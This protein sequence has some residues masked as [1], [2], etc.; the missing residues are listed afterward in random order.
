MTQSLQ[1]YYQRQT[2][3]I[4]QPEDSTLVRVAGPKQIPWEEGTDIKNVSLTGL[5]FT[6]PSDLCPSVGENVKIQFNAPGGKQLACYGLVTRIEPFGRTRMLIGI[7]FQ[8]LN[9]AQ[10]IILAQGLA[11]KLREQQ[12]QKLKKHQTRL[13]FWFYYASPLALLLT[14]FSFYA[15]TK[16]NVAE[17]LLKLFWKF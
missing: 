2:R 5:S 8:N 17:S 14:L 11:L 10:R 12:I 1:K 6:A 7:Q 13:P 9:Q 3:Y 4:L 15:S 16:W